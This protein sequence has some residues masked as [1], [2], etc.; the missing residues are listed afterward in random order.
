MFKQRLTL[1]PEQVPDISDHQVHHKED[2][3][4]VLIVVPGLADAWVVQMLKYDRLIGDELQLGIRHVPLVVRL[5]RYML[6][7]FYV[8][9]LVHSGLTALADH[10]FEVVALAE[11]HV[12]QLLLLWN[13][14]GRRG[15]TT[16]EA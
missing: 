11:G 16:G 10:P 13:N 8:V 6:F 4:L 9:G 7:A 1:L 14:F 15:H 2:S 5:D 3:V 12:S